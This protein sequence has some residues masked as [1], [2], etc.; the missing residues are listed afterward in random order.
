MTVFSKLLFG[1]MHIKSYD[2]VV[3]APCNTTANVNDLNSAVKPA[4]VQLAKVKVD[5]NFTAPCNA[6]ILYPADG[7][8]MHC[9]TALTPCAVLDVLGPPYSDPD[10]RHCTYYHDFPFSN[11]TVDGISVPEEESEGYAW[12][13]ELEK[14]DNLTVIGA[15]LVWRKSG[16]KRYSLFTIGKVVIKGQPTN[17]SFK[18]YS[19]YIVTDQRHGRALF[20]YFVEAESYPLSRPLTMWLN[21]GPG[22][23]SLAYGAFME[24]GPFRVGKKGNLVKND[25]SWNLA[26]NMLYVES[27]L[28]FGFSYSNTSS[29]YMWNDDRTA[30]DNLRFIVKWLDEFPEYG[31]SDFFLAGQSYAGHYI[32]QL[33]DLLQKYNSNPNN[34]PINLKGIALGNPLLDAEISVEAGDYLWTH[35]AISD[36]T[37]MLQNMKC[38][39][40]KRFSEQSHDLYTEVCNNVF[41]RISAEIGHNVD[42]KDLLLPQCLSPNLQFGHGT[43][44]GKI[45]AEFAGRG[46]GGDPCLEDRVFYYLNKP[47]VQQALHAN[48]TDVPVDY[49]FCSRSLSLSLSLTHT[50][51][52]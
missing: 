18:Q 51:I 44:L 47:E 32:P 33:A 52:H 34:K 45:H 46:I 41:A 6:S 12:L 20:Y 48:T 10:G 28:G 49:C 21:G 13:E 40:S 16:Y 2:W 22:C 24:H 42:E 7:G 39:Y 3:D 1:T 35:G 17:V 23:S 8:N 11:F 43:T 37:F 29:N 5:S 38:N 30:K 4:G 14:P 50:H 36:E 31:D 15:K 27:P 19:G 25:Y 9:F 26:S